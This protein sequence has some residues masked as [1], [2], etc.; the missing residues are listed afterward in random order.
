MRKSGN[1]LENTP[2]NQVETLFFKRPKGGG[3]SKILSCFRRPKIPHFPACEKIPLV[4]RDPIFQAEVFFKRRGDFQGYPP[5]VITAAV[6]RVRDDIV[7]HFFD[8]Y[9]AWRDL[10][11]LYTGFTETV[12]GFTETATGFTDPDTLS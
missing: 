7:F 12:P 4:S 9:F 8:V 11:K 2:P 1:I 6:A 5:I 3:G 10:Q